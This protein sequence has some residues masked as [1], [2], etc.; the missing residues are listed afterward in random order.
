MTKL[1]EHNLELRSQILE[2]ALILENSINQLLSTFLDIENPNPKTV[3]NKS[4]SLSFRNKLDLL[5]DLE[6]ISKD[7]YLR[8]LL[9]MEFRNQFLH[10]IDCSSF[11][12]AI[13][14]LGNDRGKQLLKFDD[15]K[16]ETDLENK[17]LN[18]F[19][20]LFIN[21][22]D[23]IL[24]KFNKRRD[25][26][27]ETRETFEALTNY[28]N[29]LLDTD[30]EIINEILV[31]CMPHYGD[32]INLAKFKTRIGSFITN[33]IDKSGNTDKYKELR[34]KLDSINTSDFKRFLKY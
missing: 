11:A 27:S 3:G 25:K 6:I 4:S 28:F 21:C 34:S 33:Q 16:F 23:V 24:E 30:Q 19:K 15:I 14:L 8:L 26:I 17:Y 13:E 9:L 32:D 20:G 18:A 31:M 10:N 22:L 2:M 29:Y 5:S 12:I 1:D 7:E